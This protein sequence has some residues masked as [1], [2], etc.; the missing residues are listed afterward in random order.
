MTDGRKP[1]DVSPPGKKPVSHTS[2]PVIVGRSDLVKDPMVRDEDADSDKAAPTLTQHSKINITPP[3][4]QAEETTINPENAV[5]PAAP[6]VDPEP[7]KPE[8]VSS[9]EEDMQE[10]PLT[11]KKE[12][13]ADDHVKQL[14]ESKAYQL[15]IKHKAGPGIIKGTL[16]VICIIVIVAA[17]AYVIMNMLS[18][19]KV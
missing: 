4:S 18:T 6:G 5:E 14:I 2:R 15:P 10:P 9:F 17:I 12:A 7:S 3:T 19:G 11:Q 1:F 16:I 13:P 8:V